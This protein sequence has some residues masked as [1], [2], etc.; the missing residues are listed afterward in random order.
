MLLELHVYSPNSTW[1]HTCKRRMKKEEKRNDSPS[2]SLPLFFLKSSSLSDCVWLHGSEPEYNDE[3]KLARNNYFLLE[4]ISG[5]CQ[6]AP[7]SN[8]FHF[9]PSSPFFITDM[10]V[11]AMSSVDGELS[12]SC[13]ISPIIRGAALSSVTLLNPP[14]NLPLHLLKFPLF[15]DLL[16]LLLRLFSSSLSPHHL[17][18]PSPPSPQ[19]HAPAATARHRL[20]LKHD[21]RPFEAPGHPHHH[22]LSSSVERR[23]L[24]QF[25]QHREGD[26]VNP[27]TNPGASMSQSERYGWLVGGSLA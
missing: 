2:L 1:P 25:N 5:E 12:S 17:H 7:P 8:S 26:V 20:W 16:L 24:V 19:P 6:C 15:Q 27:P 4:A 10:G 18:T 14:P 11:C 13:C 9:S 21:G 3:D 23:T 22:H